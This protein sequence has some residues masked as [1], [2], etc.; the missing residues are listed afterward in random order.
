MVGVYKKSGEAAVFLD[1]PTL[2]ESGTDKYCDKVVSVIAPPEERFIRIV[3]RD[4][5][6][7]D[8]AGK[9]MGA[10]GNDEFYISHS[11][12]V[13]SNTGDAIELKVKVMEMLDFIGVDL[14]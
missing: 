12:F 1:A 4:N 13:I 5:L 10:Q 7:A 11:D 14:P 6:T 8:E 3:R 2:I 9:R